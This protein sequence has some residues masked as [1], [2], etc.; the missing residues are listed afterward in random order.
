[1]ND[2]I[3]TIRSIIRK[4]LDSVGMIPTGVG[5]KL[6]G[7][8]N[9]PQY[10]GL[11]C[12]SIYVRLFNNK[13]F[14]DI[15]E[16]LQGPM[17]LPYGVAMAMLRTATHVRDVLSKYKGDCKLAVD[18]LIKEKNADSAVVASVV[19]A[20]HRVSNEYRVGWEKKYESALIQRRDESV[21]RGRKY[22]LGCLVVVVA[23]FLTIYW[24]VFK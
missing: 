7:P 19:E 8:G 2:N 18:E 11:V 4:D 23:L 6:L 24:L 20:A 17:Q 16:Y 3:E 22:M 21:S 1:M 12:E 5:L 14:D 10:Y 13:D 15:E 9:E